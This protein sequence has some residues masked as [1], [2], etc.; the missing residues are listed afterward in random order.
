M[1][2]ILTI[3]PLNKVELEEFY[4]IGTRVRS[5]YT[6]QEIP[7]NED[8]SLNQ[9]IGDSSVKVALFIT[10]EKGN[11]GRVAVFCFP[12][13]LEGVIGWYECSNS[14]TMSKILLEEATVFC[15]NEGC[16]KITGPINGSTWNNYRFNK[17]AESPLL[18]GEPYQPLYYIQQWLNFGFTES[19]TY[20][21]DIAPK[22]LFEPMTLTEGKQL[23]QQFN[24]SIDYYPSNP[25][26]EFI[27]QMY[28]FYNECFSPNPFF[29]SIEKSEFESLTGKLALILDDKHSLLVKDRENNPIAVILSYKDVYYNL[30]KSNKIKNKEHES[31]R[32]FIKTIATHPKWQGKQ[33]GTLMVNLVHNLA[34]ETGFSDIYH[35]LMFQDNLSATKGKEKFVTRKVRD[36]ALYSINL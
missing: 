11:I 24:L 12:N 25:T 30:F 34:N 5:Q 20:Q 33:I 22:D 27:N 13:E 28:T 35:L 9:F 23:A 31:N 26:K 17:T 16:K 4:A 18:P 1:I 15:K 29:K 10:R 3:N 32:L 8:Y 6:K 21:S 2:E 7:W 19:T 36:Y 14:S